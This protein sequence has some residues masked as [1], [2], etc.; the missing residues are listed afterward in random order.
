MQI[1]VEPGKVVVQVPAKVNLFLEVLGRR[2]DGFHEIASVLQEISLH[3][4]IVFAPHDAGFELQSTSPDLPLG[5]DNLLLR[6]AHLLA[7]TLGETRGASIHLT[8]RIPIAAGL[9]GG[10]SDAAGTLL[11]LSQLWGR[12]IEEQALREL[13]QQLG[14]DVPFFLQGGTAV[15]RGRGE[16]V[17]PI[18]LS[19]RMCY[20][21]VCPP[22]A[23]STEAVYK[24]VPLPLTDGQKDIRYFVEVLCRGSLQEVAECLFNRL[25]KPAVELYPSLARVRGALEKAGAIGVTMTG[26]GSAFLGIC[27]N[28][29]E[30][31]HIRGQLSGR[32]IGEVLV[33]ESGP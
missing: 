9:G 14:S 10:S 6:A 30:G 31:E 12:R 19:R 1:S 32:D 27:Q 4:T 24:G 22:V 21:L 25:E 16:K 11:G 3:D 2:P 29:E 18:G 5:N 17:T 8:K 23:A 26:S 15:C 7:D 13:A 20:V 28:K 33:V